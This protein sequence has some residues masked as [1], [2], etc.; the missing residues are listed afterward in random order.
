MVKGILYKNMRITEFKTI[1]GSRQEILPNYSEDFPYLMSD[2]EP[3]NY[4]PGGVPWHWHKAI[5]LFYVESGYIEFTTPGKKIGFNAGEAGVLNSNVL[6]MT[7]TSNEYGKN[8]Q[9]IHLF[10]PYFIADSVSGDIAK[11]YVLP[12]ISSDFEIMKL[13]DKALI[14][15]LKKS[16][17]MDEQDKFY[18]LRIR[19]EIAELWLSIIEQIPESEMHY[20]RRH[21]K[22]L[23]E[24]MIYV[25][26]HYPETIKTSD[27]ANAVYSSERECYRQFKEHLHCSPVEFIT[28]YRLKKAEEMLRET[29]LSVTEIACDCGFGNSYFVKIFRERYGYTPRQYRENL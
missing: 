11:K 3:D 5:E 16:F 17:R 18:K 13:K 7:E 24:M 10:D 22:K 15:K 27:L 26:D 25:F 2:A 12:I 14:E 23:K 8:I 1:K 19:N 28:E 6:H 29:T 20:A 21:D 9:R 4:S